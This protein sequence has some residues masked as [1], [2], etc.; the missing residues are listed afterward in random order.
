M[1]KFL[2][3]G[4]LGAPIAFFAYTGL[5]DTYNLPFYLAGPVATA[6]QVMSYVGVSIMME[7]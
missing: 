6:A 7:Y 1:R 3:S 2:I 5:R 4:L